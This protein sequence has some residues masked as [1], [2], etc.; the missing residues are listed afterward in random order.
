[1]FSQESGVFDNTDLEEQPS[2]FIR[3]QRGRSMCGSSQSDSG[4]GSICEA[5]CWVPKYVCCII[6]PWTCIWAV[7]PFMITTCI[8]LCCLLTYVQP[9]GFDVPSISF[10]AP[11][12][13]IGA[14]EDLHIPEKIDEQSSV[15]ESQGGELVTIGDIQECP[16]GQLEARADEKRLGE[17]PEEDASASGDESKEQSKEKEEVKAHIPRTPSTSSSL[18]NL[19]GDSMC[20][21]F[22][23]PTSE[24][25]FVMVFVVVGAAKLSEGVG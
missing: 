19:A 18:S 3:E 25:S 12:K 14:K 17:T 16:E 11:R 23:Q 9:E 5:V 10:K 15:E 2:D 21:A 6:V 20:T 7:L 8:I 13:S 4:V 22:L 1:M 24:V